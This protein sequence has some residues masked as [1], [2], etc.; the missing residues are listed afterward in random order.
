MIR[1]PRQQVDAI[2]ALLTLSADA[3]GPDSVLPDGS[4]NADMLPERTAG[5]RCGSYGRRET[6]GR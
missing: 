3:G 4:L 6:E 1:H 5:L 2:A